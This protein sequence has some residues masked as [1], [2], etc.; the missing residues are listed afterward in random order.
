MANLESLSAKVSKERP[1]IR[2]G[3]IPQLPGRVLSEVQDRHFTTRLEEANRKKMHTLELFPN[4]WMS[5]FG[6]KSDEEVRKIN[7]Q[8]VARLR[9]NEEVCKRLRERR[10]IRVL[11]AA[12]LKSQPIMAEHEPKK[13]GRRIFCIASTKELRIKLIKGFQAFCAEC[14]RCYEAWRGGN[15][16]VTWP[17]GAFL[18]PL[19]PR[20]NAVA[21]APG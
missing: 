3:S 14:R 8:I 9:R 13:R 17:P 18:P 19:P 21:L 20:A 16:L 15:V 6:I 5:C 4:A 10:G 2:L 11:G 12:R 7:E 1:W